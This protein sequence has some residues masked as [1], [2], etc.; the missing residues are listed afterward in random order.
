MTCDFLPACF[1]TDFPCWKAAVQV[2]N[3]DYVPMGCYDYHKYMLVGQVPEI[4]SSDHGAG[5]KAVTSSPVISFIIH[6]S[7]CC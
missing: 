7:N 2:T 6:Y 5:T 3:E 4:Q 1:L